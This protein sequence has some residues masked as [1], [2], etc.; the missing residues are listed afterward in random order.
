MLEG[1]LIPTSKVRYEE[2]VLDE[3]MCECWN[4]IYV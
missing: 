2:F 3:R 1:N 4:Y